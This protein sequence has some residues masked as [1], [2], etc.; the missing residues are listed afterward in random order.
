MANLLDPA[1][2]LAVALTA[3]MLA[4]VLA[5][6]LRVPGIVLLLATGAVLGPD[7]AG[8][9]DPEALGPALQVLVGLAVAVILFEGGLNLDLRRLRREAT[10]IRRLVTLGALITA[11]GGT[12]AARLI[13]GWGWT[14]SVLF[15]TLVIVTG[16]TVVTPLLRRIKLK[17]KLAT[18]LEA[19]GVLVDAIGAVVAVVALE[20]VIDPVLAESL[21]EGLWSLVS[22]LGFG[23]AAG[24]AGGVPDRLSA[25]LRQPGAGGPRERLHSLHRPAHRPVEQRPG[26]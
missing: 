3:A 17:R 21:A 2:L 12:L 5:R 6:H 16:P 1:L 26:P 4:Q 14:P 23:L 18:V 9:L 11:L 24:L 13:L 20:V 25:A 15:G 10:S 8:V 22:R 7:V 19:E